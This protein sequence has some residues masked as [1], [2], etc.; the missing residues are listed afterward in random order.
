MQFK[1]YKPSHT[2]Y[3]QEDKADNI[4]VLFQGNI[5]SMNKYDPIILNEKI[6]TYHEKLKIKRNIIDKLLEEKFNAY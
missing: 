3:H 2:I 6:K 5:K 1:H 4:Y